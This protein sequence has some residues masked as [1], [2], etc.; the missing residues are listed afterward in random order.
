MAL[1][2]G[3]AW[4]GPRACCHFSPRRRFPFVTIRPYRAWAQPFRVKRLLQNNNSIHHSEPRINKYFFNETDLDGSIDISSADGKGYVSNQSWF[5]FFFPFHLLY[6][7]WL[8]SSGSA[9]VLANSSSCVRG[10]PCWELGWVTLSYLI[11]ERRRRNRRRCL[12]GPC[13]E[14]K[15]FVRRRIFFLVPFFANS[16]QFCINLER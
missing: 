2:S 4:V 12:P 5:V 15:S 9:G 7:N 3:S 16:C 10:Y 1:L 14:K 11:V 8:V 6:N 13:R